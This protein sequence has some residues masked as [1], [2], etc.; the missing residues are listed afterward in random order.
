LS[1][2]NRI[3]LDYGKYAPYGMTKKV[4]V[5][6]ERVLGATSLFKQGGSLRLIVPRKALSSLRTKDSEE[7]DASVILIA[8]DKGLLVRS[9]SDYI[10]DEEMKS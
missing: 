2:Q 6:L 10:D 1:F 8:T 9:L 4:T 7:M 5:V 3:Y